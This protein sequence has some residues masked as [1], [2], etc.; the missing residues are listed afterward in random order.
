MTPDQ[1]RDARAV[2]G[3]MWGLNRPLRL[4]EMG[5]VLRLRGRDVGQSV[6]DWERG[7]TAISGPVAVAVE[8]MLNGFRPEGYRPD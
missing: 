6:H 5:R 4:S 7:H 2:L 8:A 1:L 3:E